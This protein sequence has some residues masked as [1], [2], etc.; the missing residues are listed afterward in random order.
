MQKRI[1]FKIIVLNINLTDFIKDIIEALKTDKDKTNSS[2]SKKKLIVGK[3]LD[4]QCF[5]SSS[6]PRSRL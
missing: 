4:L 6:S 5:N 3:P 1:L 2:N